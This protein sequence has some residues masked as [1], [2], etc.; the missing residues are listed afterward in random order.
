[1]VEVRCAD[2]I[3]VLVQIATVFA[4]YG[5]DIG[6]ARIHTEGQRVIDTFYVLDTNRRKFEEPQK[7]NWLKNSMVKALNELLG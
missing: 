5:L 7:I 2:A 1:M 4:K 6:F 3:G